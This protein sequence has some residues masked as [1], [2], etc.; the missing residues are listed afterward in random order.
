M[1]EMLLGHNYGN[2][3]GGGRIKSISCIHNLLCAQNNETYRNTYES[4]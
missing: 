3:G 2:V 4:A 1:L